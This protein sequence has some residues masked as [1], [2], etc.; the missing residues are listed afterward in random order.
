M[1]SEA[2][3]PGILR[4]GETLARRFD[5]K[6]V[7]PFVNKSVSE[8]TRRAYARALREFFRSAGMK[9]L[10]EVVPPGVVLWR[11]RPRSRKEGAASAALELSVARPS[12]EYL[13][14]AG[15]ALLNPPL[16]PAQTRL[17]PRPGCRRSPPGGLSRPGRRATR[18]GGRTGGGPRAL[19]TAR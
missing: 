12:F 15:A 13:K 3:T 16:N 8:A 19:G 11:D 14:A 5:P 1:S 17:V 6:S 2:P 4:G 10:S 18:C 7:A 9:H